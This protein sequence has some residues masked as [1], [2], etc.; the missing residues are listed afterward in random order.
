MI[1]TTRIKGYG[2][3]FA[4]V[5]LVKAYATTMGI[6]RTGIIIIVKVDAFGV[7]FM[8]GF[9]M[10]CVV[11]MRTN[12]NVNWILRL[13]LGQQNALIPVKHS[14]PSPWLLLRISKSLPQ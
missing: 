11:F 7:I 12:G 1:G 14:F 5:I 6:H 9:A 2:S 3:T 10:T 13:V 8:N 4:S